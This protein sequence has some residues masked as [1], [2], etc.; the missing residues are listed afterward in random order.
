MTDVR[1]RRTAWVRLAV[2]TAAGVAAVAP[3]PAWMVE[4]YYARGAYPPLQRALTSLSN[5]TS[6]AFFDP[7]VLIAT[8]GLL[9]LAV[10][11]LRRVRRRAWLG[12]LGRLAADL[13]VAAAAVYLAFLALW[14][15]NYRRPSIEE[16]LD[17]DQSRV[18]AASLAAAVAQATGELNRL[19]PLADAR[20]WPSLGALPA[21]LGPAYD[22]AQAELGRPPPAVPGRP[23]RTLL[24]WYFARAAIDGMTDPFW[25]EV[26]VNPEVLPFERPFVVAHEWGHLAGYAAESEASF[27]AWVTCLHGDEQARYSAWLSFFLRL[28]TDMP[29]ADYRAAVAR[30]DAQPRAD[31]AAIVARVRRSQPVVRAAAERVYDRFLKAN[32]LASGVR[33]Y[34]E[35]VVLILG[36]RGGPQ[37][38]PARR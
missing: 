30:L 25:L 32:R 26:L 15:L 11:R 33:S 16:T 1:R 8:A 36:T 35:V 24:S 12:P 13:A 23:K 3:T 20:P 4:R 14:G 5:L 18:N 6:L 2:V 37:G 28:A 27:V 10:V 34:D 38:R 22:A 29:P 21:W 17:F 31:L 9:W 19:A 7:F